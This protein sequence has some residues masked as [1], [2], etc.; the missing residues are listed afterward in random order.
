MSSLICLCDL[1]SQNQPQTSGQ[2]GAGIP[3]QH[4]YFGRHIVEV[5]HARREPRQEALVQGVATFLEGEPL[6]YFWQHPPPSI[7]PSSILGHTAGSV[8]PRSGYS[9]GGGDPWMAMLAAVGGR[10]SVDEEGQEKRG[11]FQVQ[12]PCHA[13]VIQLQLVTWWSLIRTP[14]RTTTCAWRRPWHNTR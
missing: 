7:C 12:E 3:I 6:V 2:K 14:P 9:H 4:F 11:V 1:P 8:T 10:G 13:W 5:G